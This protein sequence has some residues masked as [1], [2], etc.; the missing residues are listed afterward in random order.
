MSKFGLN[1]TRTGRPGFFG[2]FTF[3]TQLTMPDIRQIPWFEAV[4]KL[5]GNGHISL[6]SMS[7]R[8]GKKQHDM[9]A[10]LSS[11][12]TQVLT[13]TFLAPAFGFGFGNP[14]DKNQFRGKEEFLKL[15]TVV[16]I[17]ELIR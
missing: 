12:N 10:I 13:D 4:G 14:A 3:A 7:L 8:I 9:F 16:P 11:E 1:S 15:Y 6:Q 17:L 2:G 5:T